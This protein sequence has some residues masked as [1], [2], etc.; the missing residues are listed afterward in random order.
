[1]LKYLSDLPKDQHYKAGMYGGKFLPMHKGHLYCV[2]TA[3]KL[4]DKVYLILFSGGAWERLERELNDRDIY[5]VESRWKKVQEVANRFDNVYPIHID[6]S[7]C[8]L[9]DGREDWD[10]ETPLVLAATDSERFDAVF[11]SEPVLYAPYFERAY[12]W[13]DYVIVDADRK[14]VPISA[15]MIRHELSEEEAKKW[16]V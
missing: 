3:S 9:P 12:P 2:K 1:M 14:E 7:E 5:S 13:A 10:A 6:V 11:G 15:T 8:I 16:I 4:C